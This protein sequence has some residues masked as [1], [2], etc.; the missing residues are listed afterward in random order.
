MSPE[1]QFSQVL[2]TLKIVVHPLYEPEAPSDH[3]S[4]SRRMLLSQLVER[5]CP[6]SDN[7]AIILMLH[8]RN[9]EIK[10]LQGEEVLRAIQQMSP[11]V[12]NVLTLPNNFYTFSSSLLQ[13]LKDHSFQVTE[14]SEVIVGGEVLEYCVWEIVKKLLDEMNSLIKVVKIDRYATLSLMH[15]EGNEYWETMKF[16]F[17]DLGYE[18]TDSLSDAYTISE[19]T[20][21][22][23]ISHKKLLSNP[24]SFG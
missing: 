19:E 8:E 23:S 5:F 24:S 20:E 10:D 2:K 1:K 16:F 12:E 3:Y 6:S 13:L 21:Y 22:L 14:E 17:D 11:F 18:M 4:R 9:S 7:E 15:F